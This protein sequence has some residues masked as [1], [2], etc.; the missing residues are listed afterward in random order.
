[1]LKTGGVQGK[2]GQIK[3]GDSRRVKKRGLKAPCRGRYGGKREETGGE[4]TTE[5][6]KET[7]N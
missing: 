1:M 5:I 7:N 4:E 2:Q 3:R 6:S